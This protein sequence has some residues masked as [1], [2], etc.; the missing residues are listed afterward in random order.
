MENENL[1]LLLVGAYEKDLDPLKDL[2]NHIIKTNKSIIMAGPQIDVRPYLAVSNLL[3]FP[4]YREG[5]PNVVM[6]AGAMCLPAI[7]SNING[8][9][10]IVVDGQNGVLVTPKIINELYEKMKNLYLNP[11]KLSD[12]SENSRAMISS[13]FERQFVWKEL[14]KEYK[15]LENT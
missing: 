11:N 13:R 7:V 8:C 4:S 10:E 15:A 9:N 6:E 3:V 2:T 12:L 14:L 5:F 1:K